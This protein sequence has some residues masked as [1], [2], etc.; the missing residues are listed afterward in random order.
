[1]KWACHKVKYW[2]STLILSLELFHNQYADRRCPMTHS[3]TLAFIHETETSLFI[4]TLQ[5]AYAW[6]WNHTILYI[7]F[8]TDMIL[9]D[10]LRVGRP[11]LRPFLVADAEATLERQYTL[12]NIR[13]CWHHSTVIV[14]KWWVMWI[15]WI[16]DDSHYRKPVI[17]CSIMG[18]IAMQ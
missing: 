4:I 1:M 16:F 3:D 17:I 6:Y 2:I 10:T 7:P 5:N 15:E 12:L 11:L 18:N 9:I 8:G 14:N 13:K